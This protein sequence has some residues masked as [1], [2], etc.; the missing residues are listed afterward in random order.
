MPLIIS[1]EEP[2]TA[3]IKCAWLIVNPSLSKIAF[4]K[5]YRKGKYE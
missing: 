2:Q 4:N 3:G 1:R 5:K